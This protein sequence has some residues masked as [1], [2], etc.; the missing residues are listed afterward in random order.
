MAKH[1]FEEEEQVKTNRPILFTLWLLKKLPNFLVNMIV[2]PVSFFFFLFSSLARRSVLD[3]Q[4]RLR[5]YTNGESP[6]RISVYLSVL[7][8]SLC[9]VERLA[10]WLGKI[11]ESDI[12]Y[13]D[14]DIND[15]WQNL[16]NGKGAILIG[17]HLGNFDLLRSLST[18]SRAGIKKEIPVTV[19][20]EINSSEKFNQTLKKVNPKYE[21]TALDPK[22]INIETVSLLQEKIQNGEIIA[23]TGDRTSSHSSRKSRYLRLPFLGSPVDFPYGIFLIAALLSSAPVYFVFG[24]REK[25]VMLKP[26]NRVYMKK[27]NI[28]FSDCR[29]EERDKKVCELGKEFV[30]LLEKFCTKFPYQWYNFFD[31]WSLQEN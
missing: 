13:N 11:K 5:L 23:M 14:D 12:L 29:R 30:D 2:I 24:L 25:T 7:S 10:G 31:F 27:S 22:D 8:F 3:F 18:F 6:K 28:V 26:K 15:Y 21:L 16:L 4:R 17:S 19:L 1:W 20:M 9:V